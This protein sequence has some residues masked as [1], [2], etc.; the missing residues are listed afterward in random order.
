M[1]AFGHT[2]VGTIIG[3]AA[4][5]LIGQG[6]VAVGLIAAGGAGVLSHYLMDFMPHGHFFREKDYKKYINWVIA[7]DLSL[8]VILLLLLAH[9]LGRNPLEILYI[10]FGIGGAQLPD[11][12]TGLRKLDLLPNYQFFKTEDEFHQKTHWHKKFY[13]SSPFNITDFWQLLMLVLAVLVIFK[14]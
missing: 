11:I 12:L 2:A 3:V 9:Y 14:L 4:Y 6:D 5:Q 1:V 8:P 7:F 10:L 13:T